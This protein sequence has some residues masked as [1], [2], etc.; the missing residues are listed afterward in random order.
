MSRACVLDS[1]RRTYNQVCI[2]ERINL[3]ISL[4]WERVK[5]LE[6]TGVIAEYGARINTQLQAKH[7]P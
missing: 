5:R 1:N 3:S 2:A 4:C 7:A 6:E